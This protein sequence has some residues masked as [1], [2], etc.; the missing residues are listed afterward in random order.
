MSMT[1]TLDLTGAE[2]LSSTRT[3]RRQLD[4]AR[5]VDPAIV[6]DC[7]RL[8]LQAPNGANRQHWRWIVLAD[9]GR[10]AEVSDVYR[11]AFY[12]RHGSALDQ[13]AGADAAGRRIL[14]GARYLAENLHRVP[15]LVIPCLQLDSARLPAGNQA[16]TW[17]SLLPAVWSYM[18]AARIHG[19]ATALTTV[20]LDSEQ[21]VAELLGLPPTVHQGCLL[22][23]AHSRKATFRPARRRPLEEVLHIDGW[24]GEAGS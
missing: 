21:E 19:L 18:L 5:E 12:R 22:A 9:P 13:P 11:R 7:L 1:T 4:L 17:A 16:G 10:R 3:V 8:A 15:V 24:Q 20:H 14:T 6:K 2:L 23:T